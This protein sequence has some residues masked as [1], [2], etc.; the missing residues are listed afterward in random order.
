MIK[1]NS[2]QTQ[3]TEEFL[4]TID[5]EVK[6]DLFELLDSIPFLKILVDSNRKRSKD[7][8]RDKKGRIKIE[9]KTRM[10]AAI[11]S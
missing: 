2:V 8:E 10:T 1:T 6:N 11:H 4:K 3:L 9:K 7:L 5:K